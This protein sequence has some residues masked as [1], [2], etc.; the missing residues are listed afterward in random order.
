MKKTL[1]LFL[2]LAFLFILT[3]CGGAGGGNA[4]TP[5]NMPATGIV[6]KDPDSIPNIAW[7]TENQRDALSSQSATFAKE[8]TTSAQAA[9]TDPNRP[10]LQTVVGGP[11][12][13]PR[14]VKAALLLP[15]SGKNAD[16]GQSMLKAAQ[17]ALFDV[18][19][20]NFELSPIDTKS[21][22]AGA[23]AAAPSTS[24]T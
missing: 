16:L 23:V 13:V 20:S 9:A 7:Q 15:L 12:P 2:S 4:Y 10:S 1:P 21:T 11:A 5:W 6:T 14:K 24:R 8:Q 19:S 17:M 18:G 3:A 22:T